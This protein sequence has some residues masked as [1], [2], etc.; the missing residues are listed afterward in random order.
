MDEGE[1]ETRQRACERGAL[2]FL[3]RLDHARGMMIGSINCVEPS[4]ASLRR[5]TLTFDWR[6]YE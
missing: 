4:V 5:F 3:W 2:P 1:G 6:R